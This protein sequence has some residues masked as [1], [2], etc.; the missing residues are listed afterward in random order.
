MGDDDNVK[1]AN[2]QRERLTRSLDFY[3]ADADMKN[4][5][6]FLDYPQATKEGAERVRITMVRDLQ[7]DLALEQRLLKEHL[8]QAQSLQAYYG[9]YHLNDLTTQIELELIHQ[10]LNVLE[11]QSQQLVAELD[12]QQVPEK[13]T[14][15]DQWAEFSG[16]GMSDHTYSSYK[17]KE[18]EITQLAYNS[19]SITQ[20]LQARKEE[21][22]RK[23]LGIE[24]DVKELEF[25]M[26]RESFESQKM[27]R[28][29]YFRESYFDTRET[30]SGDQ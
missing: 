20:F 12:D 8:D 27:L 25:Q 9:Q 16:F 30:E 6:S 29:D 17:A 11:T 18:A 26:K 5:N 19:N 22:E 2:R 13:H 7:T 28:D 14:E 10:D 3:T 21:L 4:V 1:L 23:V 24:M 15:F